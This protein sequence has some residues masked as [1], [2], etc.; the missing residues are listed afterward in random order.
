MPN[1]CRQRSFWARIKL[2]KQNYFNTTI[3]SQRRFRSSRF[4]LVANLLDSLFFYYDFSV[5]FKTS[6][7]SFRV[8]RT[9]QF[10]KITCSCNHHRL[11]QAQW[12]CNLARFSILSNRFLDFFSKFFQHRVPPA[13][14][15]S[16]AWGWNIACFFTLSNQKSLFFK[17]FLW[18]PPEWPFRLRA[19]W[20]LNIPYFSVLS[21]KIWKKS[22]FFPSNELKKRSFSAQ[23]S[24]KEIYLNLI[25]NTNR[26][27]GG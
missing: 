21:S 14:Q 3:S 24:E 19:Q 18:A 9:I 6:K 25:P 20:E 11:H 7:S 27:N 16:V 10:S 15:L 4:N 1:P 17:I 13:S 12:N 23:K 8:H 22:L 5:S 26:V 2:S